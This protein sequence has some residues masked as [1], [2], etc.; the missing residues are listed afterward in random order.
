VNTAPALDDEQ[1][2]LTESP[3]FTVNVVSGEIVNVWL[4]P[5][6]IYSLNMK[7]VHSLVPGASK[8]IQGDAKCVTEI[9]GG[10]AKIR[11]LGGQCL[12]LLI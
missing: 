6:T 1:F 9:L 12:N 4:Q 11:K 7:I 8:G 3:L 5:A 2:R 10:G